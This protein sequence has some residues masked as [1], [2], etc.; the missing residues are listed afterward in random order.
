MWY[1][2]ICFIFVVKEF[3]LLSRQRK[4]IDLNNAFML[5]FVLRGKKNR[6]LLDMKITDMKFF[7]TKI[8]QITVYNTY[9]MSQSGI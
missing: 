7:Q 1:T 6:K 9:Y 8:K 4:L 2:V 3:H 5:L